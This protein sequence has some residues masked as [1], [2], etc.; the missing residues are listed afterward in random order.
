MS[1]VFTRVVIYLLSLASLNRGKKLLNLCVQPGKFQGKHRLT[2]VQHNVQG[3][4]QLREPLSYG[5]PHASTDAI[6]INGPTQDFTHRES[7]PGTGRIF[8]VAKKQGHIARE[9]FLPFFVYGLKV[10]MFQEPGTF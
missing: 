2:R 6:S 8:T 1:S 4:G 5:G 7:Y 10:C 9:A 3:P